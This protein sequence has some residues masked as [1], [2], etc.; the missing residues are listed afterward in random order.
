MN[1]PIAL[2]ERIE[3]Y[4]A[5]LKRNPKLSKL[6]ENCCRST[7][8]TALLPCEVSACAFA[9]CAYLGSPMVLD[10]VNRSGMFIIQSIIARVCTNLS[11][12]E[13]SHALMV[14]EFILNL[15]AR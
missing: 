9:I 15:P 3:R 6:Y 11:P 13:P 12:S 10:A 14:R 1:L 8:D 2:K 4:K 7:I 5:A